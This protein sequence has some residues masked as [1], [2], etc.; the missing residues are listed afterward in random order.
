[1]PPSPAPENHMHPGMKPASFVSGAPLLRRAT[2]SQAEHEHSQEVGGGGTIGFQTQVV[3]N[4]EGSN[5]AN[6]ARNH[7]SNPV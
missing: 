1:M 3:S 6:R 7:L 4:T 5:L 2:D